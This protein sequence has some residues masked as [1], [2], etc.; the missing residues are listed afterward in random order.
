ALAVVAGDVRDPPAGTKVP[1]RV[2]RAVLRG[3]SVGKTER[4]PSM[5]A[6][7]AAL[8]P[9]S[10][11][12]LLVV[13]GGVTVAGAA[14][15]TAGAAAPT[16]RSTGP[17]CTGIEQQLAGTWDGARRDA[18]RTAFA[19]TGAPAAPGYAEAV[20]RKLDAYAAQWVEGAVDVCQTS[21]VRHA[22]SPEV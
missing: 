5:H 10:R 2:R 11:T 22:Q 17:T 9:R 16:A 13:G 7:L 19:A 3:L 8:A 4:H 21:E 18:V 1:A 15:A 14:P 12:R 6:L 20:I